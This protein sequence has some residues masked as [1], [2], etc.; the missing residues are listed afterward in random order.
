MTT[1]TAQT[2]ETDAGAKGARKAKRT[3]A[4]NGKAKQPQTKK[5]K[6]IALLKTKGGKDIAEISRTLG[7][8]QHTTRAALTGLRKAG[9]AIEREVSE[10]GAARCRIAAE[11]KL[12]AAPE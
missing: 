2:T 8:Q 1:T 5:A 12:A 6:L 3:S 9:F 11:P 10:G 7:W 4:A